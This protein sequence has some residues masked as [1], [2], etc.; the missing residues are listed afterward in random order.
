MRAGSLAVVVF[1]VAV[2]AVD[3]VLSARHEFEVLGLPAR[4]TGS[5][6]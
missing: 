4:W 2:A 3:R 1:Y 6:Q 5:A